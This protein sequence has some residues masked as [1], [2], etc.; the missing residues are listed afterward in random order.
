[1]AGAGNPSPSRSRDPS[2]HRDRDRSPNPNPNPN[3]NPSRDRDRNRS[4]SRTPNACERS[5]WRE[6]AQQSRPGLSQ[7][8]P[9]T[10][11]GTTP[12]DAALRTALQKLRCSWSSWP[13]DDTDM[14]AAETSI[15]TA[16]DQAKALALAQFRAR[17]ATVGDLA[18]QPD[19]TLTAEQLRTLSSL[20][21]S[22]P[23]DRDA[24]W[25]DLHAKLVAGRAR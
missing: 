25:N 8:E 24:W 11:T 12:Q 23:A 20:P 9:E 2:R 16:A 15:P 10:G 7:P 4:R 13:L 17:Y 21:R 5:E 14:A 1:M 6:V 19:G 3:P 22:T 18:E